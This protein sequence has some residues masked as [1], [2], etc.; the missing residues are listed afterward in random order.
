MN[1]INLGWT[2]TKHTCTET[3]VYKCV[4]RDDRSPAPSIF[5]FDPSFI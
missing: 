1:L 4:N 2:S 3:I 5:I